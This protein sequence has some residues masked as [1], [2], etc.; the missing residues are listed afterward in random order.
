MEGAPQGISREERGAEKR[1]Q[2]RGAKTGSG[3]GEGAVRPRNGA[4]ERAAATSRNGARSS[5]PT[6]E[7]E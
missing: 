4:F 1:A 3:N 6:V 5:E 2:I 7:H